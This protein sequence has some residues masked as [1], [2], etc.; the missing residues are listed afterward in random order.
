MVEPCSTPFREEILQGIYENA[1]CASTGNEVN[2]YCN[3]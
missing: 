2:E 1:R 3:T